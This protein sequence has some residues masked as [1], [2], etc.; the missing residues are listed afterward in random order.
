MQ[1]VTRVTPPKSDGLGAI[2]DPETWKH[3]IAGGATVAFGVLAA[4]VRAARQKGRLEEK[5]DT[6]ERTVVALGTRMDNQHRE[7]MQAFRHMGDAITLVTKSQVGLER[8]AEAFRRDINRI[9]Q[10]RAG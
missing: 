8:D 2:T 6:L 1:P 4:V 9:D 3:A 10:E 5:V 7:S